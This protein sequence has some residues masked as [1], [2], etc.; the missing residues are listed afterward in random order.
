MYLLLS[1]LIFVNDAIRL[2]F[3][4]FDQELYRNLL[5]IVIKIKYRHFFY[6]RALQQAILSNRE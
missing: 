5:V 3:T 1:I 2:F 6:I 4:Y